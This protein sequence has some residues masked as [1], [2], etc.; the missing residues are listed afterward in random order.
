LERAKLVSKVHGKPAVIPELQEILALE[1]DH[2]TAHFVLGKAL[3]E[4]GDETG[5]KHLERA[6]EKDP[7][8][9]PLGCEAIFQYLA[10]KRRTVEGEKYRV[11]IRMYEQKV[12][13]AREERK[14]IRETDRFKA[15]G[16]APEIVR[17]L[18]AQLARYSD[19]ASAQL[20]QKVVKHFPEEQTW[21]LGIIRKR[22]WYE[23]TDQ[24]LDQVL[25]NRLVNEV[26]FPGPTHIILLEH[27]Y[28]SLR[29]VFGEIGGSEI[30]R[31]A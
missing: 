21:V 7:H 6:M 24:N 13:R 5:I 17:T 8:A 10:G 29:D 23:S 9:V 1:P 4:Q 31:S 25:I 16:I 15:H 18:R 20:V 11:R 19:L 14:T 12:E 3:I 28:K 30:Y 26:S 2:V 27:K 22:T